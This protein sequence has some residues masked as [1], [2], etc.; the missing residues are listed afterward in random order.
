MF[1]LR[2]DRSSLL[3]ALLADWCEQQLAIPAAPRPASANGAVAAHQVTHGTGCIQNLATGSA[4][5]ES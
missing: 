2:G 3:A 5:M 1:R 4:S